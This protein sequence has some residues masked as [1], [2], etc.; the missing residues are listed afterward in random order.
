M[1]RDFKDRLQTLQEELALP[2]AAKQERARDRRALSLQD[3]G[4]DLVVQE[5]LGWI[6]R[7]QDN[8]AS[9]DGG[10]ARDYSLMRGGW[11]TSYPET[12]G[13]IIPTLIE[14]GKLFHDDRWTRRA[15]RMLDW[16]V[17][18]Q[19]P[20]GGFQGGR[21]DSVPVV[22]VIF[23]TGQILLG[24]AAGTAEFGTYRQPM[25]RAAD[26]L[27]R[28]QD[29]D[30][31]WRK[32]ATP[33]AAPGEKTYETHVAW[34]LFEA[35]RLEPDAP[36]ARAAMANVRWA[37]T[38]QR[39]NGWLEKCCLSDPS[40]PLTHTLGYALRGFLEAYRYSGEPDLLKASVRTA[41]GLL[42]ALGHDGGL[43]GR[44]FS[45]WRA[46]VDWV[47]LTGSVQV[48]HCWRLLYRYT[49]DARYRDAGL[50]AN[51]FV[52]RT[53][54]VDGPLETRGAV[55]GSFPV[56]GLYGRYE[57]LNWAVKFCIDSQLLEH[58]LRAETR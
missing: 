32:H 5:C 16:L 53:I 14:C 11:A 42:A 13:Y 44:L 58:E 21:V 6:G 43:P 40:Q 49:G 36:Y 7:A 28:V 45:D 15:K 34:G 9:R 47:C 31:C 4:L 46:A 3:P 41:D 23:N 55:K 33:F 30:G 54:R 17:D 8:S 25:R 51:E 57:Y 24:L 56:D 20:D 29:E 27:V 1:L 35:A 2:K 37:L 19:M 18:I 22:P 39:S 38:N 10:V 12:T 26:W 50:K 48:A 52:R